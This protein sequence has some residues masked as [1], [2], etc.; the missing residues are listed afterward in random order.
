MDRIYNATRTKKI[1]AKYDLTMKKSLGQNFLVDGNIVKKIVDG[2]RLQKDDKVLEVGPG[3]GSLTEEVLLRGN[4]ATSIEID[5]RFYPILRENFQRFNNFK[6]V[7]GDALNDEVWK[8]ANEKPEPNVFMGNLPYVITTPLLEKIFTRSNRF[9]TV[10]VMVQKEVADRMTA[11][12]GSKTYGALSVFVS[13]F[14]NAKTLFTVSESSF[15]PRP[16]V[17][18]AVVKMELKAPE[19]DGKKFMK[20]VHIAFN[21]RRKTLLN[22]VSKGMDLDKKESLKMITNCGIDPDVRAE[23]LELKSFLRLYENF[24]QFL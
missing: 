1:M 6:L 24:K 2:A 7:E 18:S 21:M 8:E 14:S 9:K 22:S 3:I 17:K 20:F 15:I 23:T 10:V 5:S 13:F 4:S 19:V 16:K 11:A 12:P